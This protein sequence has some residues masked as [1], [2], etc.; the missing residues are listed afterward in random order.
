MDIFEDASKNINDANNELNRRIKDN[1]I[2]QKVYDQEIVVHNLGVTK[3]IEIAF[4]PQ[5]D[6]E[7][8]GL[9][10]KVVGLKEAFNNFVIFSYKSLQ[11]FIPSKKENVHDTAVSPT[12]KGRFNLYAKGKRWSEKSGKKLT[13]AFYH[14]FEF[15]HD[16]IGNNPINLIGELSDRGVS[17][18][19]ITQSREDND[20]NSVFFP[21]FRAIDHANGNGIK[22]YGQSL[23]SWIA[24]SKESLDK[25]KSSGLEKG[26][27]EIDRLI[28]QVA[29]ELIKSPAF[30]ISLLSFRKKFQTEFE[31]K[32]TS[33]NREFNLNL[34]KIIAFYEYNDLP[35][36]LHVFIS[37]NDL[38]GGNFTALQI[39]LDAGI[40]LPKPVIEE[41]KV[42]AWSLGEKPILEDKLLEALNSNLRNSL[43]WRN[44]YNR[45]T[46]DFEIF[47]SSVEGLCRLLCYRNG[48]QVTSITH[49]IKE[50]SS[51]YNKIVE[52]A[53]NDE[54]APE[55]AGLAYK[56]LVGD[57]TNYAESIFNIIRDLAGVRVICVYE[58]DVD[59]LLKKIRELKEN[60]DLDFEEDDV[61]MYTQNRIDYRKWQGEDEN[62]F[63]YRSFHV[64]VKPGAKRNKLY[65]YS[66][67]ADLGLKCEIQIR[68]ILAHGWS[69]VDHEMKYKNEIP[70]Q[71]INPEEHENLEKDLGVVSRG[72][73]RTRQTDKRA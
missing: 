12:S 42:L 23:D 61:K 73:F 18:V 65:E 27:S 47:A 6:L 66:F 41:I 9:I 22:M 36:D 32:S 58:N 38:G 48:I 16:I 56:L 35:F 59:N 7:N 33:D 49:R 11:G 60:E 1:Y 51:F 25:I 10:G 71:R 26:K 3:G 72:I 63:N 24:A 19:K 50:F 4:G 21:S 55:I 64:T 40:T 44:E 31:K 15:L 67:L 57:P 68:S 39:A 34:A 13:E 70:L 17:Y 52:R 8:W 46:K 69:D 62:T 45:R 29:N 2:N 5:N 28:N 54:T 37:K 43:I 30:K 53:N 14:G 20:E